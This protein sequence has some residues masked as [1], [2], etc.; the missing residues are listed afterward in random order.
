MLLDE[1]GEL[2]QGAQAKLLRVL[3]EGEFEP[4]GS[5]HTVTVDVRVLA[6]TNRDLLQEVANGTFREDLYYRLAVFPITLPPLRGRGDDIGLLAQTFADEHGQRM[7]RT[8]EPL[9]DDGMRRLEAYDWPGNVRELQNVI[10]RVVITARG[11]Y[12][13]LDRALPRTAVAQ[14]E[15]P[16]PDHAPDRILTADELQGLERASVRRAGRSPANTA[17]RACW[18]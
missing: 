6:A 15:P 4:V 7:G 8:L 2:P 12:V 10:E 11:G 5:S 17:R 14:V 16:A 18:A 1:V 3:Q 9:S 13:N